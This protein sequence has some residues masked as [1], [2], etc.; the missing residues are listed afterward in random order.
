MPHGKKESTADIISGPRLTNVEF[1]GERKR[2]QEVNVKKEG[3]SFF[4]PVRLGEKPTRSQ[5]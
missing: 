4:G 5:E 1:H 3:D 2:R